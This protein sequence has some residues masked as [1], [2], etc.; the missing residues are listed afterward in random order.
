MVNAAVNLKLS[1]IN[2]LD[3]WSNVK[4]DFMKYDNRSIEMKYTI[5]NAYIYK[6]NY[7]FHSKQLQNKDKNGETITP[8]HF[9]YQLVNLPVNEPVCIRRVMQLALNVGQWKSAN[10][11]TVALIEADKIFKHYKLDSIE[12]YL[13]KEDIDALS[14]LL[15]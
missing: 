1:G 13:A 15:I 2:G 11:N 4:Q 7:L 8:D 9:I 6:I 3:F 10:K 14:N 5:D 12:S